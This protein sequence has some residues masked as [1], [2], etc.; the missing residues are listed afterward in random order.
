M[1]P[2]SGNTTNPTVTF[3]F[4]DAT[5]PLNLETAWALINTA[6]DGRR[7]C[8]V[9]Y[10]RPGNEIYLYPDNGDGT[11]AASTILAGANSLTNSQCTVSSQGS[12][13]TV[14]GNQLVVTLNVTFKA[15]FTGP[16]V[17]WMAA[18]TVGAQTSAWQALG[19]WDVP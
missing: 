10:Y 14:N 15:A 13:V 9:A 12:N 1:S 19:A 16:K 11:Q 7:A 6:I 4:Q 8:Y 18:Q 2:P 3:T 5:N 17:V